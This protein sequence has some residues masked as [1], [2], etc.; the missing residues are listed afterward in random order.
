V[1]EIPISKA[2]GTSRLEAIDLENLGPAEIMKGP[3]SSLD[4]AGTRGAIRFQLQKAAYQEY[5]LEISDLFGSDGMKRW[6]AAFRHGGEKMNTYISYGWQ[7]YQGYREHSQDLRRFF[8][9]NF[10]IF[11][12][13]RQRLTLILSHSAQES[14]IPGALSREQLN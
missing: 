2:G 5:F 7:E 4:G 1:N 8:A 13:E 6:S 11:P 3:A 12:S 10:Q 14:Q 9:G